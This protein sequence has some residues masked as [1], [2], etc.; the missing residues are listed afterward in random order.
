MYF[1]LLILTIVWQN[2]TGIYL[3]RNGVCVDEN[4]FFQAKEIK[5]EEKVPG[6]N[7][8]HCILASGDNVV[9][10]AQVNWLYPD[11]NPVDSCSKNFGTSNDIVCSSAINDNETILYT[12]N[13]VTD[14]PPMYNGVYTC[15]LLGNCFDVSS[16]R[17]TVRIFGQSSSYKYSLAFFNCSF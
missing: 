8:L 12:S 16:D 3:M 2:Q 5:V 17:I 4:T 7:G 14:W 15:C 6:Q 1:P 11:N 13:S 10:N 9:A